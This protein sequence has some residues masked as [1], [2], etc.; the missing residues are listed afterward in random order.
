MLDYERECFEKN[1]YKIRFKIIRPEVAWK[2]M[3]AAFNNELR[4]G[5]STH[6]WLEKAQ[7][8]SWLADQ[9]KQKGRRKKTNAEQLAKPDGGEAGNDERPAKKA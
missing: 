2:A 8:S 6:K 7:I 5:T 4:T 3:K 1:V 9:H